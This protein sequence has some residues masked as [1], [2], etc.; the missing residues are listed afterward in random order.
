MKKAALTVCAA[1]TLSVLSGCN[2]QASTAAEIGNVTAGKVAIIDLDRIAKALGK[3][4]EI[5][6]ALQANEVRAKA[7]L[8][9]LEASLKTQIK[10][11]KDQIENSEDPQATG[12]IDV[13]VRNANL[14]L[15]QAVGTEQQNA[16]RMQ[17][18]LA[19]DFRQEVLPAARRAAVDRGMS[20]VIVRQANLLYYDSAVDITDAVVDDMQAQQARISLPKPT[21]PKVG[22]TEDAAP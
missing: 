11:H 1:I 20:V 12:G 2:Q 13:M 6:A 21:V 3:D 9:D 10:G 4:T 5:I 22:K 14:R 8:R 17:T 19:N 16:A 18:K 7:K 15:R